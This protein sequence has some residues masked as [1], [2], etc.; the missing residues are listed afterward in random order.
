MLMTLVLPQGRLYLSALP[1][2]RSSALMLL[3]SSVP[4]KHLQQCAV[5]QSHLLLEYI[6]QLSLQC[7][8]RRAKEPGSNIRDHRVY[9]G[10]TSPCCELHDNFIS[11]NIWGSF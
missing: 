10:L 2:V 11:M 6:N 8:S 4:H 1:V 3:L 7:Y 9:D 5:A